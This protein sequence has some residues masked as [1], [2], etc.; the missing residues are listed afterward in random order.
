[1]CTGGRKGA[2]TGNAMPKRTKEPT[3][4]LLCDLG[5]H[6]TKNEGEAGQAAAAAVVEL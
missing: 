5:L 2:K 1:M 4:K 3:A 6:P